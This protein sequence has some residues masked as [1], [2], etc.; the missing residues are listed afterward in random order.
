VYRLTLRLAGNVGDGEDILQETFLNAFNKLDSFRGRSHFS[1]WLYRIAINTALMH[2]R[3]SRRH[4]TEPLDEYLPQFRRDGRHK[5]IDIDYSAAS[6]VEAVIERRELM[7]LLLA[8]LSRLPE[9]Y[10]VAV[11]L[12]DLEEMSSAAASVVLG[13]DAAT[14]RQRVHRGRLML[15]GYLDAVARGERR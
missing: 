2:R 12:C 7:R 13:V 3:S 8:A 10:R 4:A 1:T 14:L 15:R 5:R 11:V 6:R 9:R